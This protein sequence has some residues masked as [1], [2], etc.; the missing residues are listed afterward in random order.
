M[1][2]A[3]E[4]ASPLSEMPQEARGKKTKGRLLT[5]SY[6]NTNTLPFSLLSPMCLSHGSPLTQKSGKA[7]IKREGR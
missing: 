5:I 7:N 4:E 1:I 2:G 6:M 3:T